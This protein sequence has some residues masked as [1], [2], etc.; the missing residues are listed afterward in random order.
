[1]LLAQLVSGELVCFGW[2]DISE[3]LYLII[4]VCVRACISVSVHVCMREVGERER[5][6]KIL[7]LA[8]YLHPYSERS[9]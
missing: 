3:Y 2:G 5:D 7:L 8:A 1:M 6:K 9:L 4:H